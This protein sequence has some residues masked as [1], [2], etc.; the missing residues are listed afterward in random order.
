MAIISWAGLG[1]GF[2]WAIVDKQHRT[3]HD[4]GSDT[5]LVHLGKKK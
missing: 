4:L 3:W 1:M 2:F 5:R